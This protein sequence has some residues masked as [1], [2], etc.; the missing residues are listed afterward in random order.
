[1]QTAETTA[2]F[3]CT[4]PPKSLMGTQAN[5]DDLIASRVSKYTYLDNGETISINST[6][7]TYVLRAKIECS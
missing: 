4:S 6:A 1:M 3:H 5:T 7:K 2:H